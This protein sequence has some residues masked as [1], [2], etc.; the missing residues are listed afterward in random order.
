MDQVLPGLLAALARQA[1]PDAAFNRWDSFLA[2]LPAGVQLLSL[3]QRNPVLLDRIAGVLGAAPM[4]SDYL[5]R[6]PAALEGLLDPAPSPDYARMLRLRLGDARGLEDTISIIRATV[7]E[8]E[9]SLAV[10]TM[11][12]RLDADAAGLL[13]SALAEAALAALLPPVQ[14]DFARRFGRVRGGSMA[15]VVMGKAGG[16]EMMAG[17]DLDMMVVYDHPEAVAQST[18]RAPARPLAASQWFIRAVHSYVAAVTAPDAE[19]PMYAVDM[20]LRPSGNKGPAA[21]QFTGFVDYQRGEAETWEQMALVR[22]RTVAGDASLIREVDAAVAEV[23]ARDRDPRKV[24]VDALAMR[25]LIAQEKGEG[26]PWDL[27]L[28][29]G[30]LI[31][32][33]FL[34]QALVLTAA[35]DR[36]SI[37][38]RNTGAILDAAAAEGLLD[39]NDAELL[40]TAYAVMRDV[41][42]WQRLTLSDDFDPKTAG[43]ALKRRLAA[44]AG[45]PDFKVLES[46]LT[47]TRAKVRAIFD[48]VM[49]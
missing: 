31:D 33:E 38:V 47:E 30:G 41:F 12:G 19:G 18:A 11:E 5:A 40:R 6:T 25:R 17:S 4:L 29:A 36:P 13:R 3:F 14:E 45:L 21:T 28:A 2:R 46:H 24:F 39:A 16:R 22:A 9:F 49:G 8:E 10:A 34:T 20:R 43:A 23:F 37:A 44:A 42:Q 27:K 15:L 1:Q 35:K 7:R 32:L 26:R 48:R